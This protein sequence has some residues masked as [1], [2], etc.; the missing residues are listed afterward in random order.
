METKYCS[1]C[2]QEKL[3]DKFHKDSRGVKGVRA[4]CKD[5][6]NLKVKKPK[7]QYLSNVTNKS[8][9]CDLCAKE[10]KP[11]SNRQK[12]CDSCR[13]KLQ[14]EYNKDY[15][16][17]TY[18]KIGYDHLVLRNANRFKT[19]IGIY[20]K[21]KKLSLDDLRCERCNSEENLLVHHK[22]RNR[23]NNELDNLELLCKSCH[24]LEHMVR[25][26]SGKFIGSK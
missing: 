5:C 14:K 10:F 1:K 17:K 3:L 12:Y 21:L 16:K 11:N 6:R 22:D 18:T 4:D 2:G 7:D 15:N 8:F 13:V 26:S 25:D 9:K 19:G 23:H 24:Q 20:Q